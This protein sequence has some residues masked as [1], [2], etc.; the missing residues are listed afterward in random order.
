TY[1]AFE[2]TKNGKKYW[3]LVDCGNF[4]QVG[5]PPLNNPV[6][7][8]RKS[9]DGG[10]RSLKPG[11]TFNFRF[12]YRN[13]VADSL[14]A[15]NVTLHDKLDL[16]KFEVV[17]P[18]RLP[19]NGSKLTYPLG[20]VPYSESYKTALVLT[21][22]LKSEIANGTKAC[23]AA[24][25]KASNAPE[26]SSG[27][28]YLCITVINPCPFDSALSKTDERCTKP[29]LGCLVTNTDVNRTTKSFTLT[30]SVNSSN[31]ALTGI[32]SY[33]YDFG[34]GTSVKTK[35]S[36][37]YKD[38]VSHTYP[39]GSY[40][41]TVVVNYTIGSGSAQTDQSVACSGKIESEPDQPLSHSKTARNLTQ[42]L[43]DEATPGTKAK[44]GDTIEYQLST[45]NS[46]GYPRQNV[47]TSDYIGDIL[48]YSALDEAFLKQQGGIY[49][50]QTKTLG[51]KNQTVG[52]NKKLTNSFR[53]KLKNPLP[54]TNQPGAM[55][56]SYDCQLSNKFGN[57][58]DIAV[59]CPLPKSAEY[60]TKRLPNTGP[61]TSLMIG[62][63][64]SAVIAYFFARSRLLR[65]ELELIRTDFA[66]TGGV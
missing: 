11:E 14:P 5:K 66:Q 59:D 60:V 1:R 41:A 37:S 12:E 4:T 27:G 61:G 15:E 42:N 7:N 17:S 40:T 24:T 3:I 63:T 48:E 19:L 32:R 43:D 33:V 54:V 28:P 45:Y 56:T 16:D 34:D 10:P 65:Q 9:I 6:L 30:T 49:N 36:T 62:F 18:A 2:G 55:T 29:V 22:R 25:M 50:V 52:A 47:N 13:Q 39:N 51:W 53:V 57:Q 64:S 38:R 31:P 35:S 23:N 44:A 46:Y 20:T 8:F 58:L 21:V 26:V